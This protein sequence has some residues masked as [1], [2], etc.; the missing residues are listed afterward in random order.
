MAYTDIKT[1]R[2]L[3]LRNL[4]YSGEFGAGGGDAYLAQNNITND[5]LVN[6]IKELGYQTGAEA[7]AA[8][9]PVP[10]TNYTANQVQSPTLPA[11]TNLVPFTQQVQAGEL[12]TAPGNVQ[13]QTV[14]PP[15]TVVA[16]TV[17]TQQ[18]QGQTVD[19]SQATSLINPTAGTYQATTIGNNAAQGTAA[20]GEVSE[21][22]T[23]QGQLKKLYSESQVGMVPDWAKGAVE[24]A[25]NVL[26]A[27]G[28][29][30]STLGAN[31]IAAAV[32]NS[33]L[34]IAAQDASTYF[35]MDM[36]NLSNNQQ[37]AMSNL[38]NKQQALLTDQAAMNASAQFNASS[39][40]QTQQFMASLV[41]SIQTQNADRIQ[42]MSQFNA[43]E[44][45]KA[46]QF[47]AQLGTNVQEFNSQQKAAI[48]T[49]NAQTAF[50]RDTFNAQMQFAVDQS[51]VLWRRT[52]N[53]GNTAAVNAANQTNVQNLYNLSQTAMNNIW[54]QFR[55]EAS[56]TFTASENDK[57]RAYN[58]AMA[59]N[60][61]QFATDQQ[62]NSF[63]QA[64]G[65]F[66]A[67]LFH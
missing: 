12:Q 52:V 34:P 31:A 29:G 2:D 33:A 40:T 64:A 5:Q 51:N 50:Q 3:A 63:G 16:P 39:T 9:P 8:P 54:Q 62:G 37:M 43:G 20:Q 14:A 1:S 53:T 17:Q 25:E 49:F 48:D 59:A 22:A 19:P 47:E 28:L 65:A 56:W 66:A 44:S 46:S 32:Q 15:P 6:K 67:G 26:A 38:Q 4:G 55:D 18:G 21:K 57:T 41:A 36:A 58:A 42:S 61:R 27:R 23:V 24:I 60:N 30:A 11:G 45:N 35:Q 13:T 10:I 7:Y